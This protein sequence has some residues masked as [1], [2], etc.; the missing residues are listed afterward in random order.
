[1]LFSWALSFRRL[2]RTLL[3]AFAP[4]F[5]AASVIH[6]ATQTQSTS[7]DFNHIG[8]VSTGLISIGG[9]FSHTETVSPT[10]LSLPR[11]DPALGQLTGVSVSVTTSQNTFAVTATGLLSLL[12]SASATRTLGYTVTS[13]TATGSSSASAVLSGSAL[14]TL[15][16]AAP[17]E[18]GGAS[19]AQTTTFSTAS[20]LAQFRGAGHVSVTLTS[21]NVCAVAAGIS[22]INGGGFA[23]TGRYAGTVTITY[24]YLP[25]YVVSGYVYVDANRN[26]FKDATEVG[27]GL[28]PY[29]KLVADSIPSGPALQAAAVNATTGY[30]SFPSVLAGIYRIV[31]DDN[32]T[33]S[34]V[35]PL[36]V[37]AGWVAIEQDT[38]AR[39]AVSVTNT[40]P[41]QN[42]GFYRGTT[43]TG[44][45]FA[46]NGAGG[47]TAHDGS[48]NGA[49]TGLPG[50][51]IK[52]VT[53][54]TEID[55]T[56]SG[57]D[58][59]YRL[60][61]PIG[62]A[63][64]SALRVATSHLA[65]YLPVSGSAGSTGGVYD[66]AHDRVSFTF[67]AGTNYMGVNFGDVAPIQFVGDSEQDGGP[68][69]FVLHR[70]RFTASTAGQVT[71]A[72]TST[73]SPFISD[74]TQTLYLDSNDN[75]FIDAGESVLSSAVGMV[76]GQSIAVVVKVGVP[77][78]ASPGSRN[79]VQ[80]KATFV[81]AG[82]TPTLQQTA[83]CYETIT[84]GQ[85]TQ[86]GLTLTKSADKSMAKP[87]DTI[88]YSI[89]FANQ[90]ATPLS[91]VILYDYTP[92]FTTFLAAAT[93]TLP[94]S[95]GLGALDKPSVGGVGAVRW[96]LT[97]DLPPGSSGTVTFSVKIDF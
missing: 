7:F 27:P 92:A 51:T 97:G 69:S 95:M 73:A 11:F 32:A 91:N 85:A 61:L 89:S 28:T 44:R 8:Y 74:W 63:A 47:G 90:G 35:T 16:S 46:D 22:A 93:D 37:P 19:L 34:D 81:L 79:R 12:S 14:L 83:S 23:G 5:A 67:S 6:A 77:S 94:A 29:A 55:A 38:R 20:D 31:L 57:P 25:Y 45:I 33:L 13:G 24:T 60:F 17:Y 10:A 58:G 65:N 66:A 72:L 62:T 75:G 68:G 15:L 84:V 30:Y 56:T 54:A 2:W 78:E 87:G 80:V 48:M 26:G 53:G 40:L 76:A 82:T 42:F 64:G 39:L 88:V 36:V 1:M 18:I 49:E 9:N 59:S 43:I 4:G 52:V 41:D 70:H 21:T 50:A 3:T 96:L 71:F 86:P